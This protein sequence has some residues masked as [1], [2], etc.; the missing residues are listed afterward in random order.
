MKQ[1]EEIKDRLFPSNGLQER[2]ENFFSF[3]PDGNFS[4][5]IEEL[6]KTIDPFEKDFILVELNE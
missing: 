3:C 2:S 1:I 4:N 6:K 5:Q